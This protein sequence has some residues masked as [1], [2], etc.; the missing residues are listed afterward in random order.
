MQH[1]VDSEG[2]V[3]AKDIASHV[4]Q[5]TVRGLT[6]SYNF[7]F[8]Y[9]CTNCITA[10]Q[11]CS[12]VPAALKRLELLQIKIAILVCDGAAINRPL[13]TMLGEDKSKPYYMKNPYACSSYFTFTFIFR[14][15]R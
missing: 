1:P 4:L 7:P 2:N 15:M 11:L 12:I 5:F 13:F 6:T 8:A 9:F 3:H 10:K 14:K